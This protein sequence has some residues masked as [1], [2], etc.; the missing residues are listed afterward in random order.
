MRVHALA[1]ESSA[2]S[3]TLEAKSHTR[4]PATSVIHEQPDKVVKSAGRVLRILEFFDARR[5]AANVVD[6]ARTLGMPQSSTSVLLRS[7]TLMGY[8]DYE[9]RSRT[10]RPTSRV[11][12]LGS[13]VNPALVQR[14]GILDIMRDVSAKVGLTTVLAARNGLSAQY[15]HIVSVDEFSSGQ[16]VGAT[17]PLA[18]S[19]AGQ[20]FLS[21]MPDAEVSK[22]IRRVNAYA[23]VEDKIV[24]LPELQSRLADIRKRGFV[25]HAREGGSGGVTLGVLVPNSQ[26]PLALCVTGPQMRIDRESE[27]LVALLRRHIIGLSQL[28]DSKAQHRSQ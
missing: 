17:R 16:C 19:A 11:A 25:Y 27:T 10:Y 2:P 5:E 3:A 15:I 6:V 9:G 28:S 24:R 14:G 22:I 12:I 26:G 7:L 1:R 20:L 13:W 21:L 4:R 18:T 23:G 8:L